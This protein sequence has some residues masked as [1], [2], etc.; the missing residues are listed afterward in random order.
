MLRTVLIPPGQST[1]LDVRREML[2][3]VLSTPWTEYMFRC[4]EGDATYSFEYRVKDEHSGQDFGQEESRLIFLKIFKSVS[5]LLIT[6]RFSFFILFHS[7]LI[8]MIYFFLLE[9]TVVY[10]FIDLLV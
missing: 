2:R 10:L 7:F 3:T 1:C 5:L 4:E 9:L 8:N 6:F